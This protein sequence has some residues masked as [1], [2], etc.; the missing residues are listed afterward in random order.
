MAKN[1][2]TK[3]RQTNN[4]NTRVSKKLPKKTTLKKPKS[5]QS[6]NARPW[7]AIVII[8]LLAV[9]VQFIVSTSNN[10]AR[11]NDM[12]RYLRNKYG[13]EFVVENYRIEGRGIGVEGD[14][15]ADAYLK[16]DKDSVRFKVWDYGDPN[17][18]SHQ[19]RDNYI[20]QLWSREYLDEIKPEIK[21]ILYDDVAYEVAVYFNSSKAG[22]MD[23][24]KYIPSFK[25]Y[26]ATGNKEH[27]S[28]ELI[29]FDM[30]IRDSNRLWKL[31]SL[32]QK[33]SLDSLYLRTCDTSYR[34]CR[35]FSEGSVNK[36]HSEVD[37][38]KYLDG[39]MKWTNNG[40]Y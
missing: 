22:K 32:L 2:I 27:I 4:K 12:A 15:T 30:S 7:I 31:V 11:Q 9:V 40:N 6:I 8:I 29:V 28:I 5:K 16:S 39:N 19:Y 3:T 25:E 17:G 26:R 14:P 1:G 38:K 23:Y 18:S 20:N 36:I 10:L 24:K 21:A 35:R 13:K 37:I 34:N 33:T